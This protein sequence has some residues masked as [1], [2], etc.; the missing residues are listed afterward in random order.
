[1]SHRV[2]YTL[3][4]LPITFKNIAVIDY[5]VYYLYFNKDNLNL[6]VLAFSDSG[7]SIF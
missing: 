5:L 7:Q 3:F 1:M 6:K 2:Y 4:S